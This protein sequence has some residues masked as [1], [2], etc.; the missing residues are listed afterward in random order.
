M[1]KV[2]LPKDVAEAIEDYLSEYDKARLIKAHSTPGR[3][4]ADVREEINKIDVM[5]LA[6][7]L[8]NGYEV[9]VTPEEKVKEHFDGLDLFSSQC[10]VIETLNILGIK[11][12][13]IN[14]FSEG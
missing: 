13:G 2:T 6:A 4:S 5:T 12:E 1:E 8:V 10:A 14:L 3:W 9:E 7:A 11:I